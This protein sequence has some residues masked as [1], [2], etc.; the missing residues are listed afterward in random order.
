M[1]RTSTVFRYR[2]LVEKSP[3]RSHLSIDAGGLL[4]VSAGSLDLSREDGKERRE[5]V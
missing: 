2:L 3:D 1:E 4:N 5:L